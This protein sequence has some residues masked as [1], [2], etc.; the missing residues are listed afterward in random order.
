MIVEIVRLF[1]ILGATQTGNHPRIKSEGMLLLIALY[2][3][4][5]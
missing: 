1:I 5:G 4:L 3:H 2:R